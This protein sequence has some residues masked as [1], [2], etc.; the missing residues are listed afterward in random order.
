MNIVIDRPKVIL[1]KI[2]TNNS[3]E[4]FMK[5]PFADVI[6]IKLK[7]GKNLFW[8][9]CYFGAFDIVKYIFET[10]FNFLKGKMI[11]MYQFANY[12]D[13]FISHVTYL[14]A[15][16]ENKMNAMYV[17]IKNKH[18]DIVEYLKEKG[19]SL[20]TNQVYSQFNMVNDK[21][22]EVES[23]E[24]NLFCT[25]NSTQ[26]YISCKNGDL[27]VVK[28][29]F[30]NTNCKKIIKKYNINSLVSIASEFNHLEIVKFL[31]KNKIPYKKDINHPIIDAIK[32]NRTE[33]INYFLS[34]NNPEKMSLSGKSLLHIA[35]ECGNF[36]FLQQIINYRINIDIQC[37]QHN[38]P[39]MLACKYGH[40]EIVKFLVENNANINSVNRYNYTP[41][42]YAALQGH[43]DIFEYL[44]NLGAII[45]INF[46]NKD[47]FSIKYEITSEKFSEYKIKQIQKR[48]NILKI[49]IN[50][51]CFNKC[52]DNKT[53][54]YAYKWN[55]NEIGKFLI[56]NG[57]KMDFSVKIAKKIKNQIMLDIKSI[58]GFTLFHE[59]AYCNDIN[60]LKTLLE[61]IECIDEFNI[62]DSN[63]WTAFH[64]ACYMDNKETVELLLEF[65]IDYNLTTK[66]NWTGLHLACS[67]GHVEIVKIISNHIKKNSIT[68]CNKRLK[69]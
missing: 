35:A 36:E 46:I 61:S 44:L 21:F 47:F 30:S 18:Y 65:G 26:L 54:T 55:Y 15:S 13:I 53:I 34:I 11:S 9:A 23:I 27:E 38:T 20:E 49:I 50:K 52:F 69:Y 57:V 22:I 19:F 17:A 31:I 68:P 5:I 56:A 16:D 6:R 25:Y 67:A 7:C 3:L 48:F 60:K 8:I 58:W 51:L 14:F 37:Y 43:E 29:L 64:I 12:N 28:Y 66:K 42:K 33:I 32:T 1:T 41:I 2:I 62:F 40:L 39:L 24:Y 10:Y 63:G 59:Y 45:D 4:E